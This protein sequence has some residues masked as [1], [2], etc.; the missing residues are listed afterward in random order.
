MRE[1][2]ENNKQ[3]LLL[4]CLWYFLGFIAPVAS[5]TLVI[6]ST[7]LFKLRNNFKFMF[8]GLITLI[9]MSDRY[10]MAF[11]SEVKDIYCLV[12]FV[13]LFF[14]TESF[15][16][17]NRYYISFL[18]FFLY[19]FFI[20]FR[21]P[22]PFTSLQKIF[23]YIILFIIVSNYLTSAYRTEG[24]QFIR[25]MFH[26]MFFPMMLSLF[27]TLFISG[28]V[29]FMDNRFKGIMGNTN[30]MG[31][32][33]S[34]LLGSF[35]IINNAIPGLFSKSEKIFNYSIAVI[36][37]ILSGSRNALMSVM[38]ILTTN[39]LFGKSK[40]LGIAFFLLFASSANYIGEAFI[41]LIDLLGLSDFYRIK[42]IED[43][44]GRLVAWAFAWEQI[45]LDWVFG[46]GFGYTPK[47]FG[48]NFRLLSL[49]GHLGNAHNS[50]LTFWLDTGIIGLVLMLGGFLRSFI[51]ISKASSLIIPFML[52]V[53]FSMF[54]ESWFTSALNPYTIQV[55]MIAT[56]VGLAYE[57]KLTEKEIAI[58]SQ[59]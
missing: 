9:F 3:V 20:S 43:G 14:S 11:A 4:Y 59:A 31:L 32:Y 5:V 35:M 38:I 41:K 23:S 19:S 54:F 16:P 51:I 57:N 6:V 28:E 53:M 36:I 46:K 39:I 49:K 25:D 27:L 8:F 12:L 2:V 1:F 30:G 22:I 56:L 48:D 13:F 33:I 15:K 18:P 42:D 29:L 40:L 44:S 10:E 47:V 50:Y 7:L 52:S 24:N 17:Y 58:Q 26:F 34:Q 55:I 21:H 45:Q 37:L